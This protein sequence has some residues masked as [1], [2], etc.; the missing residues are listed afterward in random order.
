VSVAPFIVYALPRSR[1]FWLARFLTYGDWHCGHDEARHVRSLADVASWFSMPCTGTVETAAA[2]YWRLVPDHCKAVT[3]RRPVDDVVASLRRWGL[4]SDVDRFARDMRRLDHKLDQIE[5]RVPGVLRV[6]FEELATEAGCR[7][8]FEH[9]LPHKHDTGWWRG[10][11]PVNLQANLPAILRYAQ[12]FGPQVERANAAAKVAMLAAIAKRR[13]PDMAGITFKQE[14][15]E[16]FLRDGEHL[17][18]AITPVAGVGTNYKSRNLS[19]FKMM[20]Q[21]GSLMITTARCNGRMFGYVLTATGPSLDAPDA[22]VGMHLSTFASPEF[23]GLGLKLVKAA[24]DALRERGV[25]EV[26][27]RVGN[28]QAKLNAFYRRLGAAH[29]GHEYSL[30]LQ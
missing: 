20:S 19:L 23:P 30:R 15:W 17:L 27:Y 14:I 28:D 1:T 12:A 9:C 26:I 5:K 4:Q 7:A 24:N 2:P 6:T 8:V 25:S 13:S 16:T 11:A 3:I 18:E 21:V 22:M 29:Q 10:W